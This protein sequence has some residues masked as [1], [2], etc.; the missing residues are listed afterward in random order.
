MVIDRNRG[1]R[2][3][4]RVR[5]SSVSILKKGSNPQI[6]VGK[7]RVQPIL[8]VTKYP[9]RVTLEKEEKSHHKYKCK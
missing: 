6:Q 8:T 5:T 2:K 1:S 3:C 4:K 7:K 9:F